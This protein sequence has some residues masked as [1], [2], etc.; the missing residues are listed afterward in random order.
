MTATCMLPPTP[1]DFEIHRLALVEFISTRQIAEKFGI[2]QT[3]VRQLVDRVA[4]WLIETLPIASEADQEKQKRYAIHLAAAQLQNQIELLHSIWTGT[5]DPKYL[6]Q[7]TRAILAL[8]R[9]GVPSGKLDALAAN[10]A[11]GEEVP[12]P[13]SKV[14]SQPPSTLDL[15]P[16]TLD[17]PSPPPGDCSPD[18]HFSHL[19]TVPTAAD[20]A[21]TPSSA[22]TSADE[23]DSLELDLQGLNLIESRLLTLLEQALPAESDRRASLQNTLAIVRRQQAAIQLQLSP[24]IAGAAV[25]ANSPSFHPQPEAQEA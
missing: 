21:P 11:E 9:L 16:E 12:G 10:I 15:G 22:V 23:A 3:R 8:A 18:S 25:Q 6:R 14:P 17:V 19:S 7:Q 13:T 1:R 5:A 4:E 20:A 24:N 2:S